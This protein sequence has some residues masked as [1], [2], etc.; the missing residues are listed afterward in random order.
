MDSELS[1]CRPLEVDRALVAD[2][3]VPPG[4]I[5]EAFDV[6]EDVRTRDLARGIAFPIASFGLQR[7]EETLH[8]S[9]VPA[10]A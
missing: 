8:Y 4:G 1:Y 2:G 10:V 5:V 9:V 7:G 6:V 3:R